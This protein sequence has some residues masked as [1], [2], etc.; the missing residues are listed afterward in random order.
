MDRTHATG[1]RK[2][3]PFAVVLWGLAVLAAAG[4]FLIGRY[5]PLP[6]LWIVVPLGAYAALLW[7]RPEAWLLVVPAV[8]PVVDL[9]PW[10]GWI[11]VEEVDLLLLTTLAVGYLRMGNRPAGVRIPSAAKLLFGLLALSYLISTMRGL[12]PLPRFDA[13]A[14]SNYASPY[15]ALRI[16][17]GFFWAWLLIPLFSRTAGQ[18]GENLRRWFFPGLITGLAGVCL[19]AIWERAAFP[20]LMNF[21]SDYR[22][23][24]SF[25]AMNT[26]GAALDGFLALSLPLAALLLLPGRKLAANTLGVV[27]FAA[28]V[29]VLLT[30]FSRG[31]YAEFALSIVILLVTYGRSHHGVTNEPRTARWRSPV[32]LVFVSLVAWLLYR[33]FG[34]GGYRVLAATLTFLGGAFYVGG[35]DG[36]VSRSLWWPVAGLVLAGLSVLIAKLVPKGAYVVFL[37]ATVFFA[38]MVA[39]DLFPHGGRRRTLVPWVSLGLSWVAATVLLV[40][41]HWGAGPAVGDA[42]LPLALG[43]AMAFVNQRFRRPL[44]HVE[45]RSTLFAAVCGV[46]LGLLIPIAGNYYAQERFSTVGTDISTRMAHWRDV[47][48]VMN[49]DP[50]TSLIGTGLGRFPAEYYWRNK[51]GETP[52]SFQFVTEPGNQFLRLVGPRHSA[53][54]YGDILRFGQRVR[55]NTGESYRL[56]L[57]FRSTSPKAFLDMGLCEKL[58]LYNRVCSSK[59]LE[60]KPADG[61]WHE[62][63]ADLSTSSMDDGPW[64][65]PRPLQL[66][67]GNEQPGTIVDIDNLRLIDS[68]GYNHVR[69][70]QFEQGNDFWFYT[71]DRHHLPWHAKNLWLNVYFDQGWFGLVMFSGL[72]LYVLLRLLAQAWAGRPLAGIFLASISGFLAV[73]LFDSLIDVPRIATLFYLILL[74]AVCLTAFSGTNRQQ[75]TAPRQHRSKA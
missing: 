74:A 60:L 15:H 34:T 2:L 11:F 40:A 68:A 24:A 27:L 20:G 46:A 25:S 65:L 39:L 33:V 69:N 16:A 30:T 52:G 51:R 35:R 72:V 26:G 42:I 9:A 32:L 58:L 4:V 5:Y 3:I 53:G 14:L 23:T 31:L 48:Y 1:S 59:T 64:Y 21:S 57:A 71:S 18:Q 55:V 43:A 36:P 13:N 63:T 38:A 37:V 7:F 56:A 17:K 12:L 54:Y 49:N 73:G 8:L 22:T 50:V 62:I 10:T 28:G 47:L 61:T 19:V 67:V 6:V 41:N 75:R 66:W 29:Y 70:S 44:W 45:K